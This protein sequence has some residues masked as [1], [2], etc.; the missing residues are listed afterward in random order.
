VE[1]VLAIL[2][3]GVGTALVGGIFTLIQWRLNRKAAREDRAEEASTAS[4]AARG[5]EIRD[6]KRLVN[7][8]VE[9]DRTILY[10]RIKHLGKSYIARGYIT[11]EELEDMD[12]MHEVYH[13]KEKLGGNGFLAALMKTVH[14]LEVR[15][16]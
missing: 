10:D 1:I 12:L 16:V 9:A 8:L 5:Q 6:L 3:G 13:N 14:A 11:V 15:A 2:G 7:V 4:C